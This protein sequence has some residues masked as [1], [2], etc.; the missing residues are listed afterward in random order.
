VFEREKVMGNIG[1]N[2]CMPCSN[3]CEDSNTVNPAAAGFFSM[4][5]VQLSL[6][7]T[8]IGLLLIDNLNVDQQKV[9]GNFIVAIGSLMLT[10]AAEMSSQ[11][12]SDTNMQQQIDDLKRQIKELRS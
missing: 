11:Q 3:Q 1:G 5:P 9:L 12:S 6:L 4:T 10:A 7:A 2:C 8:L